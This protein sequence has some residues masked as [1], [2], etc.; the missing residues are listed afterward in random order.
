MSTQR[1]DISTPLPQES[2]PAAVHQ[3]SQFGGDWA[4][5]PAHSCTELFYCPER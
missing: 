2:L 3:Q 1:F 4:A 5:P